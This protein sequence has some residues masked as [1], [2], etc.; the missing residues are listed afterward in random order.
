MDNNDSNNRLKVNLNDE[1]NSMTLRTIF[2]PRIIGNYPLFPLCDPLFIEQ[3]RIKRIREF[4]EYSF[5]GSEEV[6][7][8]KKMWM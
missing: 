4:V 6:N 1:H 2:Y 8:P 7:M 3:E 5:S